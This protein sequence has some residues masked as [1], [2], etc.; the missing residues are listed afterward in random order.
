M[1]WV[2]SPP[3]VPFWLVGEFTTD[4]RLPIL[5]AGLNRFG[6][7][8]WGG[9]PP[10]VPFWLVGEFTTHVRLPVLVGIGMFTGG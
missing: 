8:F 10:M 7:P 1:G 5:V 4:F 3:M 6:I 2:N 9:A